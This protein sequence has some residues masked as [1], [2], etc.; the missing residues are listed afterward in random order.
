M[1]LIICDD[2][3]SFAESLAGKIRKLRPEIKIC[4]HSSLKELLFKLEDNAEKIDAIFMDIKHKDGNG[5]TAWLEINKKYPAIKVVYVTGYGEE[6]SQSIFMGVNSATPTAFLTKPINEKYL[7]NALNK[8][9]ASAAEKEYSIGVKVNETVIIIPAGEITAVSSRGRKIIVIK[10]N[11]SY[12]IYGNLYDIRERLPGYFI[13]CHR[14]HL[15]NIRSI[16][17]I[18]SNTIIKMK[19]GAEFPIGR[20]YKSQLK[21]AVAEYY[22]RTENL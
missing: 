8:L 14:S 2:N 6:F 1:N 5:I 11:E 13:Q 19:N 21:T 4:I 7:I 10:D 18:D 22:S 9:E 15:I 3:I 12:E 17:R 20:T 16:A